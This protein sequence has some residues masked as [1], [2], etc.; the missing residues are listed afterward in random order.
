MQVQLALVSDHRPRSFSIELVN[1]DLRISPIEVVARDRKGR[2]ARTPGATRTRKPDVSGLQTE[3][4]Q[5]A[6]QLR[7]TIQL[8]PA[9]DEMFFKDAL[10][11]TDIILCSA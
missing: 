4:R 1:R 5:S 11:M 7:R 2:A 8:L 9:S 6:E 3:K 10:S